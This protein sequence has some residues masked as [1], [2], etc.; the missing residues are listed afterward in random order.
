MSRP[1]VAKEYCH[2]AEDSC[3]SP[4]GYRAGTMG[5]RVD[6]CL[7]TE[8]FACGNPV[9]T[10][11]STRMTWH[12]FGVRRVCLYCREDHE[13]TAVE[14]RQAKAREVANKA[15]VGHPRPFSQDYADRW[16]KAYDDALKQLEPGPVRVSPG[17]RPRA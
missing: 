1:R 3:K 5:G 11:C 12:R 13:K 14:R 10:N 8:C 17:R 6:P 7:V 9:C 15:T 4:S 2:V 16:T